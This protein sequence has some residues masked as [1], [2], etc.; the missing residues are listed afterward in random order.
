MKKKIVGVLGLILVIII[1]GCVK[2]EKINT[3]SSDMYAQTK[4]FNIYFKDANNRE[5]NSI[6]INLEKVYS[7]NL[8]LEPAE[9]MNLQNISIN[10]S[11]PL[12]IELINADEFPVKIENFGNEKRVF[13]IRLKATEE[14]GNNIRIVAKGLKNKHPFE[15]NYYFYVETTGLVNNTNTEIEEGD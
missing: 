2:E 10:I 1:A 6:I 5:I 12:G 15:R 11:V 13:E 7:F 4:I 14:L 3:S 8:E 9:Q